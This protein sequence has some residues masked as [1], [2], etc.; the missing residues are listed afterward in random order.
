M[1]MC[2]LASFIPQIYEKGIVKV[3]EDLLV[4]VPN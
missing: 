1:C 3:K 4:Y 2:F